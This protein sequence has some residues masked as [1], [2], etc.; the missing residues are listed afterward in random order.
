MSDRASGVVKWFNQARGYGYI[1]ADDG[2]EVRVAKEALDD[3]PFLTE[4]LRVTYLPVA[5]ADGSVHAEHV[6]VVE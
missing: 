3:F 6:R 1:D 5:D 2:S 4:G